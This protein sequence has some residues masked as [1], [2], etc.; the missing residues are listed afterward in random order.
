MKIQSFVEEKIGIVIPKSCIILC[1]SE[2]MNITS[3]ELNEESGDHGNNE[4]SCDHGNNEESC[5]HDNNDDNNSEYDIES[6]FGFEDDKV[7]SLA[8]GEAGI[9]QW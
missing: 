5:D 1:P 2:W 8:N 7:E 4:E 3:K 6:I 9:G